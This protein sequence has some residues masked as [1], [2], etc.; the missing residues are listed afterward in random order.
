MLRAAY[1]LVWYGRGLCEGAPVAVSG[2]VLTEKCAAN[3]LHRA[4]ISV[5]CTTFF[6]ILA[7]VSWP[8]VAIATDCIGAQLRVSGPAVP[9][10]DRANALTF[11][12]RFGVPSYVRC[13]LGTRKRQVC[14]VPRRHLCWQGLDQTIVRRPQVRRGHHRPRL[15]PGHAVR[16]V[17]PGR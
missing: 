11:A 4:T 1:G 3:S 15:E 6:G 9:L 14:Q 13:W 2:W 7:P 10:H 16:Q 12:L 5:Q 17:H 8:Y